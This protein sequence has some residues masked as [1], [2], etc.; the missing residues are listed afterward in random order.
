MACSFKRKIAIEG[1][2]L[3]QHQAGDLADRATFIQ[4]GG[5]KK[6]TLVE[7]VLRTRVSSGGLDRSRENG[8]RFCRRKNC[9]K[10]S[11]LMVIRR[12]V[13]NYK[14]PFPAATFEAIGADG[15]GRVRSL[16]E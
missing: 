11:V 9:V 6:K 4:A 10:R 1:I 5:S 15:Y 13:D 12:E 14:F 16:T 2:A 8:I 7:V 3:L